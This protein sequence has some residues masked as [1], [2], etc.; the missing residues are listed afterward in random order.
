MSKKK[1]PNK[2]KAWRKSKEG[3]ASKVNSNWDKPVMYPL[4]AALFSRA[5][6]PVTNHI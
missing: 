2:T 1:M 6:I 4:L 3:R 5:A